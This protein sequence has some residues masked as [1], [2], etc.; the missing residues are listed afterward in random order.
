MLDTLL[1]QT[2]R[3]PNPEA[4]RILPGVPLKP[5][6]PIELSRGDDGADMPLAQALLA[7]DGIASILIGADFVTVV[8]VSPERGWAELKPL[9]VAAVADLLASGGPLLSAAAED[10]DSGGDDRDDRDDRDDISRQIREVI[11]RFV[12]P[13][14]ARDGGEAAFVRFDAA[15][16]TAYVRMGGACG[17]CPSGK[18]TLKQGIE[19]TI[20][21]Y[22]PEVTRVEA[23]DQAGQDNADPKA[24]FRAWIAARMR[25]S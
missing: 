6:A 1:I 24:R 8:R 7:I 9:A 5:G 17:G 4:L 23:V 15:N 21:H 16:G 11:D 3:T 22:V 14:V 18:T 19:R 20:R 25:K 2:E 10:A 12:R 13:M